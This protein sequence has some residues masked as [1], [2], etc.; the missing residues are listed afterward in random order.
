MSNASDK[1]QRM[2]QEAEENIQRA[3]DE[4]ERRRMLDAFDVYLG[5][6]HASGQPE[7]H[8]HRLATSQDRAADAK[9]HKRESAGQ[10]DTTG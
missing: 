6:K 5:L 9:R 4:R 10:T 2:R 7:W 1:L 8:A 3:I